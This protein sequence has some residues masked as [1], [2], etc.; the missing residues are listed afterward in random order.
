MLLS[1]LLPLHRAQDH[2]TVIS[3][4]SRAR[5]FY[6][7]LVDLRRLPE[8]KCRLWSALKI[9]SFLPVR[10]NLPARTVLTFRSY[11][12]SLTIFAAGSISRKLPQPV[13][14]E[15]HSGTKYEPDLGMARVLS[16]QPPQ[17]EISSWRALSKKIFVPRDHRVS[18]GRCT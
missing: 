14:T 16:M 13:R 11:L 7:N 17:S 1:L 4:S 15:P 8:G 2:A 9:N 6:A 12:G 5:F 18:L 3:T 10:S